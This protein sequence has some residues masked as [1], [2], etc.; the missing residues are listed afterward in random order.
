MHPELVEDF[1]LRAHAIVLSWLCGDVEGRVSLAGD[2]A[3]EL[4]PMVTKILVEA[5]LRLVSP[6]CLVHDHIGLDWVRYQCP[7]MGIAST[8]KEARSFLA[9]SNVSSIR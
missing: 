2:D 4:L 7:L 3:D 9:E 1:R 6:D 8:G 5:L